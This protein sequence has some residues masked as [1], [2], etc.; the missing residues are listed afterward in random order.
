VVSDDREVRQSVARAGAVVLATA[1]FLA[2]LEAQG[3]APDANPD[4]KPDEDEITIQLRHSLLV[5]V[6]RGVPP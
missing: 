4:A 2:R 1:E 3:S 5:P 6:H